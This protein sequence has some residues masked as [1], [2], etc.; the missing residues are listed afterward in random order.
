[1]ESE[2]I[3]LC[4]VGAGGFSNACIYP[5]LAAHPVRLLGVCDL[6]EER[7]QA[8]ARR[9]GFERVYT[10]FRT[11]LETQQ[12]EAVIC[13]GG[14]QVHYEVGREVLA[15]GL[16]LYIQKS[17]APDAAATRELAALAAAHGVPCHVGF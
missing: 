10:D 5:Q 7:A 1:M 9:Y 12:P 4:Y 14:P 6:V 3:T 11:M 8:A 2:P 15:R 16:P 13:V 17:P